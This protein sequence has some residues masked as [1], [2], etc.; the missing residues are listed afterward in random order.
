MVLY[1][2]RILVCR[3]CFYYNKRCHTGWGK[4]SAIYCQQGELNDFGRGIGG[5]I[6]PIF[7]GLMAL[8][9]FVLAVISM[10]QHFSIIIMS[11][12]IVFLF[13]VVMSSVVLRKKSCVTCQ[14]K[15]ICPG[16][17]AR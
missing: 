15:H 3:N 4:L 14:M 12:A 7:Y 2:M 5:A 8:V 16:S 13:I 10:I 1:V 11:L 9:P 17:A 6:I